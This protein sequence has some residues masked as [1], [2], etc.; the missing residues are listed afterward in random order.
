MYFTFSYF[1]SRKIYFTPNI[2]QN[3]RNDKTHSKQQD[4]PG[5]KQREWHGP[6]TL[7]DASQPTDNSQNDHALRQK[8]AQMYSKI[9]LN[10]SK[11]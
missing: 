11:I 5:K 7:K 1:I 4:S 8:F 3:A 9:H 2:L 6:Q 10:Q